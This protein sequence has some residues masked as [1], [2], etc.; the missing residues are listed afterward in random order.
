MQK[1]G[2]ALGVQFVWLR[3]PDDL[4]RIFAGAARAQA[5]AMFLTGGAAISYFLLDMH[6]RRNARFSAASSFA[7]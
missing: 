2:S 5:D 7:A 6:S 3:V 1:V 4:E